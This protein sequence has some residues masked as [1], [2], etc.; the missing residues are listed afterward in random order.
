MDSLQDP[1]F[2]KFVMA[3]GL[4]ATETKVDGSVTRG[5]GVLE[6]YLSKKRAGKANSLIPRH[7]REGRILDLGCGTTPYFLLTT[8]FRTKFGLEKRPANLPPNS[9]IHVAV[10]DI[11]REWHLPFQENVFDAVTMLA[12]LEHLRPNALT[13]LLDEIHRILRPGGLLVITTPPSWTDPILALFAKLHLVSSEEIE[14]H[15]QTYTHTT[16]R[17]IFGGSRFGNNTLQLGYFEAFLNIW[18]TATKL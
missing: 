15:Q 6:G 4:N 1:S 7:L 13:K 14:E 11:E 8:D 5:Y 16:I 17:S 12:V 9:G 3:A 2:Q 18:A 10:F